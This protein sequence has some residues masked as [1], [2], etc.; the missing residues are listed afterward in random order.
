MP[1]GDPSQANLA[2]C[3]LFQ[4]Q[5]PPVPAPDAVERL[6]A[7]H[8]LSRPIAEVL[9]ARQLCDTDDDAAVEAFLN[10]TFK[11]G[12]DPFALPGVSEAVPI[13]WETIRN[14][15]RI[16]V[17]GDFDADGVSAT[18]I[19]IRA[20][21]LFGADAIP[22]IP[23]RRSEGYGLTLPA[24]QRCLQTCGTPPDLWIT[25]DCGITNLEEVQTLTAMGIRVI[26]TDHHELPPTLP[27]AEV[28]VNP[29]LQGTPAALRNLCGAGVAFKL[30]HALARYGQTQGHYTGPSVSGKILSETALA[31]VADI[32]PLLGENRILVYEALRRWNLMG[33]G[34]TALWQRATQKTVDPDTDS[35][36]FLLAPRINAAGRMD[37]AMVAYRLLMT[38][39]PD[40]A[41]ELARQLDLFNQNRKSHETKI[42]REALDQF[43][44][45]EE[46][47]QPDAVVVGR[48][49]DYTGEKG[50]HPGVV[51]IVASRLVERF[52]CPAAVITFD[53]EDPATA[54][55]RGSIRACPGY[56]VV[57]TLRALHDHLSAFGGHALAGGFTLKPGAYE[58]FKAGFRAL[59]AKQREKLPVGKT[60]LPV[61]GWLT[62]SERPTLALYE[63]QMRLAPFG[64]G[65]PKIRWGMRRV[66]VEQVDPLGSA[67]NHLA[68][69]FSRGNER[70]PRAVW[71]KQGY[72]IERIRACTFADIVFEL[73]KNNFNNTVSVELHLIDFRAWEGTGFEKKN[74]K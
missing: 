15:R 28:V 32:V 48:P 69:T 57:E 21:T 61:D 31:T 7:R 55:G 51:G 68:L 8:A 38:A 36:A 35:L 65:N 53:G 24:I 4:W 22:F 20:L 62:E 16:V 17:F 9:L 33:I 52:H 46:G 13:I 39:D 5:D 66:K 23:D 19:L 64:E 56:H 67:G 34:L 2:L 40:E 1:T 42:F 49:L 41:N 70:L 3:P 63:E 74:E 26:V 47:T 54:T 58:A 29:R 50:W 6:M 10:P 60:P 12:V 37:S 71:F 59:C 30:V 18:A 11:Q 14:R 72:Q 73:A 43:P 44:V 45:P 27:A 25:V